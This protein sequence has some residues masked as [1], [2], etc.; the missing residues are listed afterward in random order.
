MAIKGDMERPCVVYLVTNK[1]TGKRYIG[2]SS[3]KNI[4]IRISQHFAR[5]KRRISNGAFDRALRK[6][7]REAFEWEILERCDT[8]VDALAREIALIASMKPEYNSTKGGDGAR[9]HQMSAASRKRLSD[10]HKGNAWHGMPHSE[11]TKDRLRELGKNQTNVAR[12]ATYAGKAQA[13]AVVCLDDDRVY[14]SASS[15]ARSVGV[16]PSMV[17]EVCNRKRATAAGLVFRYVG[18]PNGG[19]EEADKVR[20]ARTRTS[21]KRPVICLNDNMLFETKKIAAGFYGIGSNTVARSC[22]HDGKIT[23]YGLAFN[24]LD[25]W[26]PNPL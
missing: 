16:D 9:G 10:F 4:E 7:A 2:V 22:A 15:A 18:E 21:E 12:L 11:A 25:E 26:C 23:R 6:Y 1:V 19:R 13:K 17:V 3:Q 20:R 24:F 8:V 5:A 14:D